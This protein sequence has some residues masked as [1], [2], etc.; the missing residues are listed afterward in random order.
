VLRTLQP[1][2]GFTYSPSAPAGSKVSALRLNGTAIDPAATY[3]LTTND[4]LANG[5]D[6]STL[7]RQ[8]TDRAT[9]PGF[10]IDALENYLTA[11]SPLAS[12]ATNRITRLA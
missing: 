1:S 6:G 11:K 2:A 9:A 4:F 8:G 5:S 7:L 12:A 3:R 10:D